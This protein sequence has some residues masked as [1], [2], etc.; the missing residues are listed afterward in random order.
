MI[1]TPVDIRWTRRHLVAMCHK[2][3]V[4]R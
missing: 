1:D 2:H 4:Y 3:H